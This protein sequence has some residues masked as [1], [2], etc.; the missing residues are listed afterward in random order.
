[1]TSETHVGQSKRRAF[2]KS[3]IAF[4]SGLVNL[5]MAV[6]LI[7][8]A[9]APAFKKG[10]TK[11]VDLGLVDLLKGARYKKIN[12]TFQSKDG[13]VEANRERSVYV[14]DEG[15]GNFVVFSRVCTHLGCL[16]R[17]DENKR[18][19]HCPCHGGVF[20]HAGNVIAG[21]PPRPLERRSV[22]VENGILY[23]REV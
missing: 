9:I 19:F 13:W 10:Q 6:P 17:W 14:T 7:G 12:Y 23:V 4:I 22:K 21:P 2:F 11:W 1:M 3:G 18:H 20:D 5:A 16:V 8:S 15:S